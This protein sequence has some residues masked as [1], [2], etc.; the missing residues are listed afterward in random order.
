[1]GFSVG[2]PVL[3]GD[4]VIVAAAVAVAD[5]V[6]VGCSV[7]VSVAVGR[8]GVGVLAWHRQSSG[9]PPQHVPEEKRAKH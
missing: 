2:V 9:N 6:C 3:V 7:G 1:V 4:G 5:G 8:V